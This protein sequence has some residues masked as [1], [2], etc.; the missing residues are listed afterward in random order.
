M[1]IHSKDNDVACSEQS[2]GLDDGEDGFEP[3]L[4]LALEFGRES[5]IELLRA[6]GDTIKADDD[7]ESGEYIHDERYGPLS[8]KKIVVWSSDISLLRV[9][10]T[11][12]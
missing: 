8:E 12:D 3:T 9:V 7:A 2:S 11:D 5:L 6:V 4:A 1:S 10:A